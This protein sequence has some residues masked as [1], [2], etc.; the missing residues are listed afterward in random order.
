MGNARDMHAMGD[1]IEALS[2]NIADIYA[3][4]AGGTREEWRATMRAA[5]GGPDGTWYDARA[6]VAAGLA[7]EV[8]G[9]SGP[10]GKAAR[11]ELTGRE[12]GPGPFFL[13]LTEGEIRYTVAHRSH[14][15]G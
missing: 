6:A 12:S 10:G 13:W 3:E 8:R 5:S 11:A 14:I 15:P 9:E 4:H 2:D 1:L 7:D